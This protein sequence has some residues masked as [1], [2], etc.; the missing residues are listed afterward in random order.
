MS[1]GMEREIDTVD[2]ARFSELNS[3]QVNIAQP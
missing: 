2:R 1:G 3:V